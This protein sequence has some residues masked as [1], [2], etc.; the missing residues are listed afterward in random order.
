M[1][2]PS[3]SHPRNSSPQH[4]SL[5][6]SRRVICLYSLW[7]RDTWPRWIPS[8]DIK[9]HLFARLRDLTQMY[10]IN[11]RYKQKWWSNIQYQSSMCILERADDRNRPGL[12]KEA[13]QPMW[14]NMEYSPVRA[15]FTTIFLAMRRRHRWFGTITSKPWQV[16]YSEQRRAI[17]AKHSGCYIAVAHRPATVP[18]PKPQS[19][20]VSIGASEDSEPKFDLRKT[21]GEEHQHVCHEHGKEISIHL[22]VPRRFGNTRDNSVA[23]HSGRNR[24]QKS[25]R[26][27]LCRPSRWSWRDTTGATWRRQ[28]ADP[29]SALAPGESLRVVT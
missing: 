16:Q 28:S 26:F 22:W 23:I 17:W 10:Q 9:P 4:P 1:Y 24:F 27:M 29:E 21:V 15:W 6:R 11:T 18:K 5:S 8:K 2:L 12:N 19:P 13:A 14:H 3:S 20:H 25:I 7:F